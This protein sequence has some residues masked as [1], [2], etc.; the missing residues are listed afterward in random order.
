[1]KKLY[2]QKNKIFQVIQSIFLMSIFTG[3][4]KHLHS[5][6]YNKVTLNVGVAYRPKNENKKWTRNN[7]YAG[8]DAFFYEENENNFALGISDGVGSWSLIGIDPSLFSWSLMENSKEYIMKNNASFIYPLDIMNHAF[9]KLVNNNQVE[10]GSATCSIVNFNKNTMELHTA[11]LGDSGF[12]I[13][14]NDSI[15]ARSHEKQHY[16]NCPFQLSTFPKTPKYKDNI[17]DK[18]DESHLST[19]KLEI[20]DYIILGTDGL[21]DNLYDSQIFDLIKKNK[22]KNTNKI[23]ELLVEEAFQKSCEGKYN[24]PFAQNAKNNGMFYTGG[25]QDDITVLIA[26]VC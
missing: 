17:S 10:A 20:G 6:E 24:S 9:N 8:E 19:I 22:E 25:K 13:I 2:Y 5:K 11:N 21:F 4:I 1:M 12:I 18:P 15:L 23:S 3:N 7:T 14:R 16:F 26:K